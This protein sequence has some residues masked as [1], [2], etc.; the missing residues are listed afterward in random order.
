MELSQL[1]IYIAAAEEK[2]FTAAADRLYIN[3][4]TVSRTVLAL[5]EELGVQ[6]IRR[7]NRVLALTAA[8]Q[9]L[10]RQAQTLLHTRDE[11]IDAVRR[12]AERSKEI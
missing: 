11:A 12:T 8:G 2:S 1:E 10:L 3:H 5:E 7:S 9:E 6:L 4:S